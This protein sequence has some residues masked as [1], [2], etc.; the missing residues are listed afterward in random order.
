MRIGLRMGSLFAAGQFKNGT[1]LRL[2]K[3][4][5]T[6]PMWPPQKYRELLIEIVPK[7]PLFA[8]E[9]EFESATPTASSQIL[10]SLTVDRAL[11]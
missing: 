11:S 8:F 2:V 1:M 3:S 5:A 6:T 7:R 10:W 9:F 4:P